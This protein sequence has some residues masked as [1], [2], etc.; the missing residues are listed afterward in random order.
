MM[1]NK[2]PLRKSSMPK[3]AL[4][5][6]AAKSPAF[7][8][9]GPGGSSGKPLMNRGRWVALVLVLL[10]CGVG[11]AWATGLIG[12][13]PRLSEIR[14]L[15]A[16]MADPSL[17][18]DERSTLRGEMR[19]K[20]Q[21]LPDDLRMKVRQERSGGQAQGPGQG[22]GRGPDLKQMKDILAMPEKDRLA[23][24]D[25]EID[26]TAERM[27]KRQEEMAKNEAANQGKDQAANGKPGDGAATGG[28]TGQAGGRGPGGWGQ[29]TDAQARQMRNTRLSSTPADSRATFST[30]RQL[31]Q[32]RALQKGTSLPQW[33]GPR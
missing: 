1:T 27:K 20:M 8:R 14:D 31:M 5:K 28:Q 22:R 7:K 6:S 24:L 32:A 12:P 18:D 16:R 11:A 2:P 23:A 9:S 4:A 17:S 26:A 10:F 30:F 3:A 21:D 15:R 13:D 25:K 19:K 29:M 33:G